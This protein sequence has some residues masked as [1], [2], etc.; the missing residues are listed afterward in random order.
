[1]FCPD[2]NGEHDAQLVQIFYKSGRN[3]LDTFH[4][5]YQK[6]LVS[7]GIVKTG[8]WLTTREQEIILAHLEFINFFRLPETI[9]AQPNV[10]ISP[11]QGAQWL[12]VKYKEKDKT[13]I[14]YYPLP[15]DR[16][17]NY[18]YR[19]ESTRDLLRVIIESKPE[20]KALPPV[21]GGYQ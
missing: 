3:E 13:V 18:D 12:R 8:M 4:N 16:F 1:M 15:A 21:K 2:S 20:Y 5:T 7:A 14:W 9:Y 19:L 6:D 17:D 10:V 11:D